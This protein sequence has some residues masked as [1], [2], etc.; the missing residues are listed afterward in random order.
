MHQAMTM[1]VQETITSLLKIIHRQMDDEQ[2]GI[3]SLSEKWKLQSCIQLVEN[4]ELTVTGVGIHTLN[5]I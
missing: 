4:N 3:T 2:V 1:T 5:N